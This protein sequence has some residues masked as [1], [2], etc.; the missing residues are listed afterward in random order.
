VILRPGVLAIMVL[1]IVRDRKL[2]N[3]LKLYFKLNIM[4]LLSKRRHCSKLH[5]KELGL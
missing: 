1:A 5:S 3:K 2:Y 4:F